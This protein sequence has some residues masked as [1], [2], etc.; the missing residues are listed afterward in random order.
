MPF[1]TG[2]KIVCID[3]TCLK[4]KNWFGPKL[5]KNRIYTVR[6]FVPNSTDEEPCIRLVELVRKKYA[7]FTGF[8]VSRFRPIIEK[9][10]DISIFEKLLLNK[11]LEIV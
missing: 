8:R 5:V 9:K 4:G 3:D 10:T 6:D 11:E 1:V 7:D 2:Q